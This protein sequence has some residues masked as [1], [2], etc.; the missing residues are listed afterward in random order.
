MRLVITADT[1]VPK[2]ARDLPARLWADIEAA[3]VVIHAGDWVEEPL[4]DRML[5]RSARLI[6]VCGNNDGPALRARLPEI[7]RAELGGLRFAVVHETGDARGRD[8]GFPTANLDVSG[9]ILPPTGVY[10]ARVLG[11]DR[12]RAAAVNIGRRP[13]LDGQTATI[14]VEAHLL[15]FRGDLY[16][17]RLDLELDQRLREEQRFPSLEALTEQIK[18]DLVNVRQWAGNKGLL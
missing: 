14:R 10:A 6:G 13:T 5:A 3:D 12:P 4:L 9:L 8:L 2:R 7:A 11:A 16:G 18:R 17:Q 15:G 1:H